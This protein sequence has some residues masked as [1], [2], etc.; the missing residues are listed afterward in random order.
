M[1][2]QIWDMDKIVLAMAKAV[3]LE[4]LSKTTALP[5]YIFDVFQGIAVYS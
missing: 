2:Q 5:S 4:T 3:Q 1:K